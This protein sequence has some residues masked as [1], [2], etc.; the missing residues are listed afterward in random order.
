MSLL[1]VVKEFSEL[2]HPAQSQKNTTK[3]QPAHAKRQAQNSK[4]QQEK[5]TKERI[6]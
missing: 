3:A 4:A 6:A 5:P 1:F 2:A